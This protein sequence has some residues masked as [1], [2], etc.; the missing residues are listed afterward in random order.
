[1]NC[2]EISWLTT[3]RLLPVLTDLH[4][5]R[6]WGG[7][8]ERAAGRGSQGPPARRRPPRR[9]GAWC[10]LSGPPCGPSSRVQR[11][12]R[13]REQ[14]P[15][16]FS[17]PGPGRFP[18]SL[19]P[20]RLVRAKSPGGRQTGRRTHPRPSV[21]DRERTWGSVVWPLTRPEL[22]T[23][24]RGGLARLSWVIP[25][26]PPSPSCS[27]LTCKVTGRRLDLAP[28]GPLSPSC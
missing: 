3:A 25:G 13:R 16:S 8:G 15:P 18:R 28:R 21:G 23:R 24:Q 2:P 26:P 5:G 19:L 11:D 7:R 22:C 6:A 4:L 14:G 27:V 1:M 20:P 12:P 9:A 10:W 17:R